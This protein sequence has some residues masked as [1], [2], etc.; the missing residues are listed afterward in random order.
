VE[1]QREIPEEQNN[2]S[3][4]KGGHPSE[5]NEDNANSSRENHHTCSLFFLCKCLATIFVNGVG[6]GSLLAT[7]FVGLTCLTEVGVPPTPVINPEGVIVVV[8]VAKLSADPP[9]AVGC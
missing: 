2:S 4:C 3:I 1:C 5:A 8:P 9:I 7:V 6:S